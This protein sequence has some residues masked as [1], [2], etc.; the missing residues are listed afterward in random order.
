MKQ[1]NILISSFLAVAITASIIGGAFLA[2]NIK[3]DNPE[4]A[5][6]ATIN[7][8][9]NKDFF[10]SLSSSKNNKSPFQKTG[11]L[12]KNESL[13]EFGVGFT[14]PENLKIKLIEKTSWGNY[15]TVRS[16]LIHIADGTLSFSLNYWNKD[17]LECDDS[18][19]QQIRHPLRYKKWKFFMD[20]FNNIETGK[21]NEKVLK[22][23]NFESSYD[24]LCNI[25]KFDD[26]IK[27]T[28]HER[29]IY[30]SDYVNIVFWGLSSIHNE[31]S[32]ELGKKIANSVTIKQ[33]NKE[34]ISQIE[35]APELVE[36]NW[37]TY[38]NEK[39]GFSL[40][41][42]SKKVI[43]YE[44][45]GFENGNRVRIGPDASD[46]AIGTIGDNMW[47]MVFEEIKDE[48]S[49]NNFIKKEY[50]E[51]CGYG[52]KH[53]SIQEGVF[54]IGID[55]GSNWSPD[56]GCFVNYQTVIKYCP[57]KNIAVSWN[58]GQSPN[59]VINTDTRNNYTVDREMIRSF[60]FID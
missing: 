56:G 15:V 22:Q 21:C 43:G 58:I 36:E 31:K 20:N 24:N 60:R 27:I 59:F 2:L 26:Y 39:F 37:E 11:E 3:K 25:E 44:I 57:S 8:A 14:F 33:P 42:P 49:L 6:I 12:L 16:Q 32:H 4:K 29:I 9:T 52:E 23:I 7:D 10:K 17:A 1:K 45:K 51:K 35:L 55:I 47:V 18:I 19:S 48:K 38:I 28:T 40:K 53:P 41:V 54:D 5:F 50:G 13:S 46:E 34:A 30:F